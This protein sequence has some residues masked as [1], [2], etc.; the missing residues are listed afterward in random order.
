MI[1]DS[2]LENNENTTIN[3]NNLK[4][5]IDNLDTH[6]LENIF[7]RIK[8]KSLYLIKILIKF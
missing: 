4:I 3:N 1:T 5:I 6:L 7:E 2:E 8:N